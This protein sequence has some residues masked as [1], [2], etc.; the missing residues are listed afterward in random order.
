VPRLQAPISD[1]DAVLVAGF[2][3]PECVFEVDTAPVD[4]GDQQDKRVGGFVGEVGD[5]AGGVLWLTL[6]L[7]DRTVQFADVPGG[8]VWGVTLADVTPA[9]DVI[10]LPGAHV[11]LVMPIRTPTRRSVPVSSAGAPRSSSLRSE[12]RTDVAQGELHLRRCGEAVS[13]GRSA[14]LDEKLR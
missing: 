14:C 10:E 3:G 8:L 11:G 2:F 12:G 1:P 7:A 9:G 4:D 13:V 6:E 5:A